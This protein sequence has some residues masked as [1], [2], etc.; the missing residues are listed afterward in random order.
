MNIIL[1]DA[2]SQTFFLV[3]KGHVGFAERAC[4]TMVR[5]HSCS[6]SSFFHSRTVQKKRGR[7]ARPLK[8]SDSNVLQ[9]YVVMS[10][11]NT[12]ATSS[13]GQYADKN[14]AFLLWLWKSDAHRHLLNMGWIR[15]LCLESH[16]RVPQAG[17]AFG[18]PT[19]R[20]MKTRLLFRVADATAPVVYDVALC[21]AW[22]LFVHA[23]DVS[24]S[25]L[26]G[27]RSAFGHLWGNFHVSEEASLPESWNIRISTV[28]KGLARTK[29]KEKERGTHGR[30]EKGKRALEFRTYNMLCERAWGS[31]G[32]NVGSP[33]MVLYITLSW[34]LMSR[35][36]NVTNITFPHLSWKDDS[37]TIM[38]CV[39]KTNQA[40]RNIHP[41]HVYANPVKPFICPV[42]A[43]GVYLLTN[44]FSASERSLFPGKNQYQRFS[45]KL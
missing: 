21:D 29:A 26:G 33:F 19:E 22:L 34:N 36:K 12:L 24:F 41:R 4:I 38:F 31:G 14:K 15:E 43:L 30:V 20:L 9:E 32:G 3:Q 45:K 8:T 5:F 1:R 39:T 18:T 10:E 25:T 44:S 35:N 6:H 28:F 13:Q 40:G 42:L 37:L 7:Q 2:S 23:L 11:Q 16:A 27:Y 17:G